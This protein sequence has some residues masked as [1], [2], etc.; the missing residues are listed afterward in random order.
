M[1]I[2]CT[3]ACRAARRLRAGWLLLPVCGALAQVPQAPAVSPESSAP[4]AGLRV[5]PRVAFTQTISDTSGASG[6]T[7]W[8]SQISPGL[9]VLSPRGRVRGHFDYSLQG[10]AYDNKNDN[11][12]RHLLSANVNAE[13]IEDRLFVDTQAS[14][15]QQVVSAFGQQS[16]DPT[17]P[18]DNQAEQRTFRIAPYLRGSFARE[19]NYL[20]QLSHAVTR[21]DS[22]QAFDSDI[23]SALLRLWGG[24][25]LRTVSWS[26]DATHDV[27]DFSVNRKTE[28]QRLRAQVS[29]AVVPS[30]FVSL[31]G[32]QEAND[33]RTLDKRTY[34]NLGWAVDWRPGLRTRVFAQQ[35]RRF[36]GTGHS[37]IAEHRTARTTIRLT[38]R[39][40]ISTPQEGRTL[41]AIGTVYDLYFQQFAS[42]EPDPALRQVL[43]LS[44][45]Q[46]NNIDPRTP[47]FA[48]FLTSSI[49]LTR[50]QQLAFAWRGLR[51]TVTV[52]WQQNW[53]RRADTLSTAADDFSNTALVHQ[54]GL[55]VNVSHRLTPLQT[56]SV[57]GSYLRTQGDLASQNTSL[58]SLQLT[59]SNR[60][61][62]KTTGALSLRHSQFGSPTQ[63]YTE[64]A[65]IGSLTMRF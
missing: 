9:R 12:L 10:L 36:F 41:A 43:V 39:T 16:P 26:L 3:F 25:P 19:A 5:E 63:P 23:T 51:Q 40:D 6:R 35:E 58:R 52:L 15:S 57:L 27:Y 60:L 45:L 46:A 49:T 53:T 54:R 64:N 18:N 21:T 38:D 48:G 61:S 44:F 37:I 30:L 32:G 59:W 14:I 28:A 7:N 42:I 62:E 24:T 8:I 65:V 2:S 34:N 20:A 1:T 13:L 47:I 31:I 56:I 4:P 55:S 17:L 22:A 33:L 50:D 11:D 29:Y